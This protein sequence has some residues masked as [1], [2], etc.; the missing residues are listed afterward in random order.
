MPPEFKPITVP[1][2]MGILFTKEFNLPAGCEGEYVLRSDVM[3][4]EDVYSLDNYD[5]DAI[6]AV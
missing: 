2:G 1:K 5:E 4:M 6:L 3:A